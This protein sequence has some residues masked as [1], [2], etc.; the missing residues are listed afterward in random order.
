MSTVTISQ[1]Q[2]ATMVKQLENLGQRLESINN[3][4]WYTVARAAAML[5]SLRLGLATIAPEPAIWLGIDMG[6]PGT[7]KTVTFQG[8]HHA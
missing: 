3:P 6:I 2:A 1:Q 7:D 5:E 4:D 8:R